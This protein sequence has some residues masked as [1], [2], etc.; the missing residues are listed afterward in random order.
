MKILRIGLTIGKRRSVT[1]YLQS[2]FQKI[3]DAWRKHREKV[4]QDVLHEKD[5]KENAVL[6]MIEDKK[7]ELIREIE[8]LADDM[9]KGE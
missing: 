2:D 3:T 6:N 7:R 1:K 8:Q 9:K 4:L 5:R